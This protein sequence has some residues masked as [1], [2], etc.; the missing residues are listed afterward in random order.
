MH[1]LAEVLGV[2]M[3]NTAREEWT[4]VGQDVS[5]ALSSWGQTSDRSRDANPLP[6][7]NTAAVKE[8]HIAYRPS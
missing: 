4:A 7:S 2:N 8:A 5:D 1:K 3:G 6:P